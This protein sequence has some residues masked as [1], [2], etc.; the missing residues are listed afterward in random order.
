MTA[1]R[2]FQSYGLI[3][4]ITLLVWLYAE[5]Q[6][7]GSTTQ[8]ITLALPDRVGDALVVDFLAVPAGGES[9]RLA[10]LDATVT[11]KGATAPL[12]QVR[13]AIA[14]G[15]LVLPVEAA[16]L[17]QGESRVSLRLAELLQRVRL[18][19]DDPASPTLADLGVSVTASDP[20]NLTLRVDE[21]VTRPV[22]V[23]FNPP[24]VQVKPGHKI[25]PSSV[26]ATLLASQ[27]DA[28]AGSE[29]ALFFEAMISAAQLNAMPEDVQQEVALPLRL[30]A[31]AMD[32]PHVRRRINRG[33]IR[34]PVDSVSVRFTIVRQRQVID[35]RRSVPVW[36]IASPSE[37]ARFGIE[38][39]QTNRVLTNVSIEGPRDLV[40]A[41]RESG[42]LRVIARFELSSDELERGIDR[43]PL[44]SIEIIEEVD[45]RAVVRHSVPLNP[46]AL[47]PG[48]S[49]RLPAFASD[50]V[51]VYADQAEVRF[52]IRRRDE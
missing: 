43:A 42:R 32:E 22:R 24:S 21:L 27:L 6:D 36:V 30:V 51:K 8:E 46:D 19:A 1:M 47:K 33:V 16:D 38:L 50:D 40:E 20:L 13:A 35:L 44:S 49:E 18:R 23:V 45:G 31:P 10:T 12:S 7:V 26:P 25:D 11:F 9:R 48:V 28:I 4:L 17:P 29:D 52:T 37:L 14:G 41:L 2:L 3:T 39:E 5:G 34:W 15:Q